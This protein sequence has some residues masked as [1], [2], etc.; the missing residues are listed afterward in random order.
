MK[1]AAR[2]HNAGLSAATLSLFLISCAATLP[3]IVPTETAPAARALTIQA[4]LD[5]QPLADAVIT[6][7]RADQLTVVS[8]GLKL[9]GSGRRLRAF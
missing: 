6:V 9:D 3:A 7:L 1:I 8:E 2:S 5:G 4:H